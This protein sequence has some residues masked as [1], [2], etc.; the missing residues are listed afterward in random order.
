MKEKQASHQQQFWSVIPM[1]KVGNT[2]PFWV[3]VITGNTFGK[4]PYL[5]DEKEEGKQQRLVRHPNHKV[6]TLTWKLPLSTGWETSL[7]YHTP[8]T[9]S[10]M[11]NKHLVPNTPSTRWVH[12]F[13]QHPIHWMG[14]I[15]LGTTPHP[16]DGNN[17][18]T[19]TPIGETPQLGTTKF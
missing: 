18:C 9:R 7:W 5:P 16:Q 3:Q 2:I 11:G 13:G 10:E 19:N 12:T 17:F 8:S 6:G 14:N 4:A 1:V 15:T